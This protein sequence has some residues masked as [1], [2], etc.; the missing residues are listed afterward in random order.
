MALSLSPVSPTQTGALNRVRV[1]RRGEYRPV[2]RPI[3]ALND[4]HVLWIHFA[5]GLRDALVERFQLGFELFCRA[6]PLGQRLIQEI[7]AG[8][9]G[10]VFVA[11]GN[12]LPQGNE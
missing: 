11:T 4:N 5:D 8:D 2:I 7:V 9:G 3:N 6:S 10:F 1:E 12:H